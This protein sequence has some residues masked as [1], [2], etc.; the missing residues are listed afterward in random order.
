MQ[1]LENLVSGNFPILGSSRPLGAVSVESNIHIETAIG[2]GDVAFDQHIDSRLLEQ[3]VDL[4]LLQLHVGEVDEPNLRP[5]LLLNLSQ[6]AHTIDLG[7]RGKP[8]LLT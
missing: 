8:N 7:I 4:N 3:L 5:V 2:R 6:V 1:N